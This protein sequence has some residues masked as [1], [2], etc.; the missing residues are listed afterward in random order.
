[1]VE[2]EGIEQL[3]ELPVLTNFLKLN[4]VLLQTVQREL[5]LVV[6]EYFERL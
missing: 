6:D 3:V 1:M 2:L 5:G 4:I